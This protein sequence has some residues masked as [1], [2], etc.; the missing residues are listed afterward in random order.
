M[1]PN[2]KLISIPLFISICLLPISFGLGVHFAFDYSEKI[3]EE[4]QQKR[5]DAYI[6]E[7]FANTSC[8]GIELFYNHSAGFVNNTWQVVSYLGEDYNTTE[9]TPLRIKTPFELWNHS[10]G[11]CD[12]LSH[13]IMC[14]H[15]FYP[16]WT[17]EYYFTEDH[18]G[19]M[20]RNLFEETWHVW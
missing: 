10:G 6:V 14:L 11:D 2:K 12:D 3:L 13:T 4:V 16:L 15:G 20:C 5:T 7:L 1:N 17:C 8:D 19:I 18:A 9:E